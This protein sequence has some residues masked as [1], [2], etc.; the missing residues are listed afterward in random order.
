MNHLDQ[1]REQLGREPRALPQIK[2]N[3][4]KKDIFQITRDDI[5]LIGYDPHPAI[6]GEVAV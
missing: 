2:I 1:V 3:P 4:D 5:T 6:K